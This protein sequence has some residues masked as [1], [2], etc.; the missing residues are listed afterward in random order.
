MK[1]KHG[2]NIPRDH[3][4]RV[5][6]DVSRITASEEEYRA[7]ERRMFTELQSL[8]GEMEAAVNRAHLV[9]ERAG[10]DWR[11]RAMSRGNVVLRMLLDVVQLN[12]GLAA[13]MGVAEFEAVGLE[14]DPD[15]REAAAEL[16]T[17]AGAD[18]HATLDAVNRELGERRG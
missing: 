2:G 17:K 13:F 5:A 6:L 15:R 16:L 18:I 1:R 11:A 3:A 14:P 8:R 9:G 4:P 12:A 10:S 7:W